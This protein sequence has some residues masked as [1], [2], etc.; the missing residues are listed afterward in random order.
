VRQ[1]IDLVLREIPADLEQAS[2]FGS[3]ARGD[4]RPDSDIDILLIFR[5]LP[6]DREPHAS[7]AEA[8][9]ERVAASTGVPV[10]V[11]SVSLPDLERGWRT[12]MLVDALE[13]SQPLWCR[14]C[15]LPPLPF[16][17]EDALRC[18]GSLLERV[19]EGSREFELHLEEGDAERAWRRGRDDIVRLCTAEL[20]LYGLTRPRR[21]EAVVEIERIGGARMSGEAGAILRWAAESYGPDGR[22]EDA[23]I[24]PPPGGARPLSTTMGSLRERVLERRAR[25]RGTDP[26]RPGTRSVPWGY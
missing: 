4:D 10:T 15:P 21:G 12:P 11:W 6:P 25:L 24:S 23:A 26:L 18:V 17:P 13:D 22:D 19:N 7:H 14:D 1:L 20:L 16:T 3:R 5:W 2:L 8:L 9:A